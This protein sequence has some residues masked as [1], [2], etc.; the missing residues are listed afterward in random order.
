MFGVLFGPGKAERQAEDEWKQ[1]RDDILA[2]LAVKED[3]LS[4][5]ALGDT[6]ISCNVVACLS[7]GRMF[8]HE[9]LWMWLHIASI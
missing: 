4:Y 8:L 1:S 2:I 7:A 9:E 5:L 6:C 3:G